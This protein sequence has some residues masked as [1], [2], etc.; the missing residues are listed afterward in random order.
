MTDTRRRWHLPILL[1]LF[2]IVGL[3]VW[4]DLLAYSGATVSGIVLDG[5][6]PVAGARVRARATGNLTFADD[7]GR[8]TL[9]DLTPGEEVEITAWAEGYYIASVKVTPT[10]STPRAPFE[11]VTNNSLLSADW[12]T[13]TLRPHHTTDHPD[14]AWTSPISGTSAGACGNCHPMIVSQWRDNAHGRAVDNPRFFSLYQG[15]D[16]SSTATISPGYRLDFPGTAGNCAN[17]HAPGLGVD[18]YLTTNMEDARS[19]ITAGIHCDFCHK[20]GGVY[21]DPATGSIYPNAPGAQSQRLLR[22]PAGDNIFFGPYDDIPDPDTYLPLISESQYCAPCHQFSF[23]GTPIYESYD[24]WLASPYAAAGVTCQA[25]HMPPSGDIYFALPEK[26]GLPHPPETIPSH[27]QLGASSQALLQE[28]VTMTMTARQLGDR[29][30]ATVVISNANAGHHVPTDHPGRH[31]IL[32]VHALDGQG[33]ELRLENGPTVPDWGGAQAGLPGQI[34]A[35]VLQDV[36]TGAF[37]VTS[38]WKQTLV[39]GDNRL[40]SMGSD[41]SIYAFAAPDPGRTVTVAAELRFR[42]LFQAE[43]DARGWGMPDVIMEQAEATTSIN[44]WQT[45]YLPLVTAKSSAVMVG[46]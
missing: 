29:I 15:T 36:E 43:M 7:A 9:S 41:T 6:G 22:P 27:L 35:K 16:I 37:P 23:W 11:P 17:C 4:L 31:L 5:E 38:Y 39:L 32:T 28:T 34:F 3:W 33:Q 18:G 14:Y 45:V 46:E 30:Y 42:R 12:V 44:Q 25:C 26:G 40:P 19:V 1:L 24:E 20:V 2:S 10:L 21:L 8:F 13:L